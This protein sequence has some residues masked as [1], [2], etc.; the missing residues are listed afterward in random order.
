MLSS[1]KRRRIARRRS[2]IIAVAAR[3]I[4]HIHGHGGAIVMVARSGRR[5]AR[6]AGQSDR[7]GENRD[8]KTHPVKH[9]H[10]F[11]VSRD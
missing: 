6:P 4:V 2:S 10:H 9:Y 7:Q 1:A 11:P 8:Q 3:R 5:S